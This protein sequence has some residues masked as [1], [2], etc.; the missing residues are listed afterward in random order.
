MSISNVQSQASSESINFLIK[1]IETKSV[2]GTIIEKEISQN[3][4]PLKKFNSVNAEVKIKKQSVPRRSFD[5]GYKTRVLAAYDACES[6][7]ERGALLRREGLYYSR[8]AAWKNQQA[9]GK[10]KLVKG[11]K[12]AVRIDHLIAKVARLE[13]EMAQAKVIIEIQKKVSDLLG[14]HIH[15]HESD[16]TI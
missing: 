3:L 2:V 15:S 8:I 7:V 13:K 14:M 9:R 12:N 11:E 16:E 4:S 1:E 10:T 5:A 6:V